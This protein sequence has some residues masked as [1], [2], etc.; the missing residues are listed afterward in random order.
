MREGRPANREIKITTA[1]AGLVDKGGH[2][3]FMAKEIHEQPEVVGHT[4]AHYLDAA[5]PA[6]D[7]TARDAAIEALAKT[8]R[9]TI[10]ACGTAYYAGTGRQILVREAGAPAGGSRCR[11]GTALS[12]SGLS[13]GRRGAV[14][15]AIGRDRRHAGG[16]ARRQTA[17][18]DHACA[19]VNV[20]ESSIA[21]E[22]DIV[23]PTF[24]GPEIGVASTKAFTCQL[25]CWRALAIAAGRARGRFRRG[26][27]NE[28]CAPRCW[29]SRATSSMP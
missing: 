7:R 2:R 27:R 13:R 29:R 17:G 9:L 14:H 16:V 19:I 23:L 6:D 20:P 1:S 26:G 21:R 8:S 22:A 11:L 28:H 18:P 5:G 12:R 25:A 10:S 24:A 3:H 4:L 15:L